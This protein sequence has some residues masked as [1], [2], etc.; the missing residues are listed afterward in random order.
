MSY[1][2]SAGRAWE[3]PERV[4][5]FRE[6]EAGPVGVPGARRRSEEDLEALRALGYAN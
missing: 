4:R 1:R 2:P 5:R 3:A 6:F